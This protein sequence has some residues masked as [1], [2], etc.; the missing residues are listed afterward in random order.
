MDFQGWPKIA[1]LNR[2]MTITEKID[3]TNAQIYIE[4]RA[5][6]DDSVFASDEYLP[7]ACCP[8]LLVEDMV[9]VAGSRKRWIS[10]AKDNYGFARWVSDN[11]YELLKLG[12]GRHFGEWWGQGIQRKYDMEEKKLS[13]FNQKWAT[14]GPDCVDSVPVL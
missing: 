4:Y 6:V 1:R 14:E 5:L 3:G 13:M 9:M 12:P 2:D 8:F 10:P 11:R 7:Q